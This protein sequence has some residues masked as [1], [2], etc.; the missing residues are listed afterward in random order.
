MTTLVMFGILLFGIVAYFALPV[1]DL[2]SVDYPTIQVSANLPGA[3]AE[4]MAAAVATPLEKQFSTIAGVDSMSSVSVLGVTQITIQF[5]LS[6]DIDSRRPGCAGGHRAR[7]WAIAAE[8][9]H[10]TDV[11][12]SESRGF[13]GPLHRDVIADAAALHGR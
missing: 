1:S 7:G 6:R 5:S 13:A 2:P 12:Q 10:A 8:H 4:T 3:S 9:A 11:S